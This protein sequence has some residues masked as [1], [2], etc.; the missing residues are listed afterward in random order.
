MRV[1]GGRISWPKHDLRIDPSVVVQEEATYCGCACAVMI[2][3]MQRSQDIPTQEALYEEGGQMPF[4]VQA[5]A[6]LMNEVDPAIH[7]QRWLGQAVAP[8]GK[9]PTLATADDWNR[10]V[11]VLGEHGPWIAQL[12]V[13]REKLGHWVIVLA[14]DEEWIEVR[15]PAPPGIAYRMRH[16]EFMEAWSWCAVY[17]RRQQ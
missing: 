9:P 13:P 2:L 8:P 6:M 1:R 3:G 17:L 16:E 12:R 7:E 10:L 15:D 5:L 11:R 14:A 4:S